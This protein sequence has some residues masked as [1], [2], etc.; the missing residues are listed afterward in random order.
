M[1][2][3]HQRRQCI[4][5][6]FGKHR[7]RTHSHLGHKVDRDSRSDIRNKMRHLLSFGKQLRWHMDYSH[8]R[9]F[10]SEFKKCQNIN[11]KNNVQRSIT[12][13]AIDAAETVQTC[14]NIIL[15]VSGLVI[16]R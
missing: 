12:D 10:L 11:L 1:C 16:R 14:T 15:K 7:T 9:Q 4:W 8:M 3:W 13:F 5:H 2:N 6:C